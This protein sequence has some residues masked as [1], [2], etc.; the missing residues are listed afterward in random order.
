VA[1]PCCTIHRVT[2]PAQAG[3]WILERCPA[4]GD[5]LLRRVQADIKSHL[6]REYG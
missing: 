4:D 1:E 2:L 6:A 3:D 5:A